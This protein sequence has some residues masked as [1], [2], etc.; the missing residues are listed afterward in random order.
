MSASLPIH[1]ALPR[2]L[3]AL[4]QH[5]NVVLEA[6]PGAGKSTGV[7]LA[8]LNSD[9]LQ[10]RKILMLEP[11]RL[12]TRAVASR[13]A[14][15]LGEP[16][17]RTVGY[18]TRLDT[19]VS[20]VTRI[21]VVTEGVLTRRLQSD[22]ALEGV[23][24]VIFDEFH[25]RSL[26]ADLGLA[27]CLDVQA[28]LRDD[29]R[30]LV[31]SATLDG[32]AVATLLGE[33]PR[34]TSAGKS[35]AVD[36][37]YQTIGSSSSR[38]PAASMGSDIAGTV[39]RTLL[40]VLDTDPGDV[41]AF[42]PGQGEIRRTE[43]L[44]LD[45]GLPPAVRILPLYGDL[46][47]AQQDDALRPAAAGQRKIVLATNIAET[48]LTI[49]GI[50][51]VVD[52]GLE[53]RARFHPGTGMSRLETVRISR[54]AA[55]QR[56]GRAG[57][58]STG[59]CYRL[60]TESEQAALMAQTPAEILEADLAPLALELALWGVTNPAA[61][62]WLDAPPAA[63]FAQAV[64]LLRALDAV[65]PDG[66]LTRQGREMST[67]GT[68][69]RL[70]HM[71][72]KGKAIGAGKLATE[73]A[74]ILTER[75][76][77][78]SR[79]Y[80]R[81]ADLRLRVDA[82]RQPGK[83]PAEL[84]VDQGARQRILQA[85]GVLARQL[86]NAVDTH[87]LSTDE[88]TGVLLA[89]AY[90]DRIGLARSESQGA[91]ARFLLSG[92][93]GAYLQDPQ[94]LGRTE[95]LVVA[96]LD[97]GEREARIRLAAPI[98]RQQVEAVRVD[99]IRNVERIEWDGRTGAVVARRERWLDALK[100]DER[101]L[102][103]NQPE[104]VV[105]AMLTGVRDLGLDALPWTKEARALQTRIEFARTF[106]ASGG[107]P[108][109]EV[110]DAHLLATLEEWLAPW[111]DGVMRRE[112]LAKL[113]LT[114]ILHG[115][116]DWPQQQRLEVI[117]PTHLDVPSGS[118]IP[119]EYTLEGPVLAVRLQ[120]VFGMTETPLIGGGKVPVTLHLL[121]PARRPVQ[122]T[123]DLKSFWSRGYADV[124]KEL[125]GRYPKHFWPDNPLAAEATARAKPKGK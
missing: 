101:A 19:K 74:A 121:S 18:R 102:T 31:M 3:A 28:T 60:W 68:H 30:L 108:W 114:A 5:R 85:A 77:L 89:Y 94:V 97:A 119:I 47:A 51:I 104:R 73:V 53:R 65:A 103:D 112:H 107:K 38:G 7:P 44:L 98:T 116:L 90:P 59:V 6:P 86:G 83:L 34:I 54:S 62:R 58:L 2:L 79:D 117:A 50:R 9:W 42:L 15:L 96:E 125:K 16:V 36:T 63:S 76:C 69:P 99:A 95:M 32:E 81:D 24:L 11:R 120:E 29:L 4:D 111:I 80:T 20:A 123:R 72:L 23:A 122:V 78:K 91:S 48:S 12:A 14:Q 43:R 46:P 35:Y 21:E 115:L 100:L 45:A 8:L 17:G 93:R 13:M 22:Q 10:S 25:E 88:L 71:L 37:R 26:N 41:L 75:D 61:L 84:V 49:E 66:R 118:R 87:D 27:L 113:S 64:D 109:P 57:R 55:D 56:R 106:D 105:Q 33:A 1:E 70:A 40:R 82:L 52:S 39:A 124:R 92:G 67:L 110:N